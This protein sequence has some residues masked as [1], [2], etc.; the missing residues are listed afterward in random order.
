MS[1]KLKQFKN[2]W[3][4]ETQFKCPVVGAMVSI[5]KHKQILKKCGYA[6][7]RMRPYEFHQQLMSRLHEKNNVSIMVN[8]F[9]QSQSVKHMKKIQGLGEKQIQTL[10]KEQLEQGHG[11]PMMYAIIAHEDTSP[12][13]LQEIYG[14]IHMKAHTNMKEVF[15]TKKQLST[16]ENTLSNTQKKVTSK[17]QR[18]RILMEDK[19]LTA[20][21]ISQLETQNRS[22][23][24]LVSETKK[25]ERKTDLEEI[26]Q[27][28]EQKIA[29]LN[30][31]IMDFKTHLRIKEREKKA[32]QIQLFESKN[33][34]QFLREGFKTLY[35]NFSPLP[36]LNCAN[37]NNCSQETC[38]QYQ[39]CAK[40]IFMIGGIT[41]MKSFYKDIVENAG[42]KFDYHD[43]YLKN[44][45]TNLEA[46]VKRCDLVLCPVNCNSHNACLKIKAL[47]NRH[48]KPL[49]ILS[50]S[51]LTAVSHALF[52]TRDQQEKNF[53]TQY[54]Q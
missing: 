14:Q 23:T 16:M 26:T 8:N 32:L 36:P 38:P 43:G 47:C 24:Q 30:A 40:Q 41:K 15:D 1:D 29:N 17:I 45:H 44:S 54:I 31:I 6:V 20:R 25:A 46:R 9:I 10:W 18:I 53:K 7:N 39:L 13:L 42:G 50:N 37:N 49:K 2:I 11:G 27:P 4:V 51:S 52:L 3:E 34:N 48:K 33:E 35:E 22:L 19:K 5:E 28:Y 12:G 21:K